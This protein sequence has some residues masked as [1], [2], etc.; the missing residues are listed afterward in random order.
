MPDEAM[1]DEAMPHEA[2]PDEANP[3]GRTIRDYWLDEDPNGFLDDLT[4][5][6][7]AMSMMDLSEVYRTLLVGAYRTRPAAVG[8]D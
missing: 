5:K 1:P 7:P 3:R 2:M 4:A 6:T 8:S